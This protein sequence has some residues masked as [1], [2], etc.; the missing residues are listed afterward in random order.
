[1]LLHPKRRRLDAARNEAGISGSVLSTVGET[2][3]MTILAS[4]PELEYPHVPAPRTVFAGPV[5]TPT[6]PVSKETYPDIAA[7]LDGGRTIVINLGSLFSY[8]ERDVCAVVDAIVLARARLQDRGGFQ[9]LWKL[10]ERDQYDQLI[11][12]RLGKDTEGV[13]I[14]TW[15]EPP[16]LAVLQHPNLIV[17]VHHGGASE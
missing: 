14:E 13:R 4:L 11:Q 7:F 2:A 5:L 12:D 9:V 8:T 17:A 15:I 16:A 3:R 6:T 10:R 1:L